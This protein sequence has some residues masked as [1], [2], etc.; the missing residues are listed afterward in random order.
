[1]DLAPIVLFVYNRPDHTKRTLDALSKNTLAEQSVLYIFCDGPKEDASDIE[2]KHINDVRNVVAEK[3]WCGEVNIIERQEN[4]GLADSIVDGITQVLNK[5]GEVIV[6]EDDIITSPGFLQYMNDALSLYEK[7]DRVM[8]ISGYWFPIR[9][10]Y[11]LPNT[12]FYNTA[13]CWGWATWKRAWLK[14]EADPV[15]IYKKIIERDGDLL[16][17]NIDGTADFEKQ[18]L[19]NI[20]GEMKTW[21]V[22]WY[23]SIH[24]NEGYSLHPNHSLCQNIGVDGSGMNIRQKT[25]AY[26]WNGLSKAIKVDTIP[27]KE[28]L[29]ARKAMKDFYKQKNN[30][31]KT[32]SLK[33]SFKSILNKFGLDIIRHTHQKVPLTRFIEKEMPLLGKKILVPDE[34]SFF[35]AYNEIFI[36]GIY[37]FKTNSTTPF[38]LDC[39]ANIGL[40]TIYIKS[41][42]PAARIIAFEPD[43]KIFRYLKHNVHDVFNHK[44]VDLINKGVYNVNGSI[45]FKSDGADG[46]KIL[47]ESKPTSLIE[48]VRLV[49]FLDQQVDFL[50]LDIEGSEF[51]VLNDCKS[52]LQSVSNLF[53]EYHSSIG[54]DQKLHDILKFL[55][56]SGYRYYLDRNSFRS[57]QP[58]VE[59]K[60]MGGYDLLVNIFAYRT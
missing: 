41:I 19:R 30:K 26:Q 59:I 36:H 20:S 60:S 22:K 12:F 55:K 40:S 46:G 32:F 4:W 47:A 2:I 33:R 54:Q 56:D 48:T 25:D 29:L 28:N 14:Y 42:F 39:G 7:E 1:M 58:F 9:A 23:G 21:A 50:K 52:K 45:G 5:H 51:E 17:F 3:N 18:L 49:D 43:P 16:K 10:K 38:I 31:R 37:K 6:L 11:R 57:K 34:A 15:T 35:S 44:D 53:V 13:S 8:H 24:L 27:I